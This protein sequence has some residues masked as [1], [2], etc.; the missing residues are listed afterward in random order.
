MTIKLKVFQLFALATV[1]LALPG[2]AQA[3]SFKH[4]GVNYEY[5]STVVNG[6]TVITGTADR[7][8]FRFVV[9]GRYVT[10]TYDY[11]P[12]DFVVPTNKRKRS[13]VAVR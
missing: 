2:A 10:G 8:P 12:V 9:R 4:K 5:T 13:A 6:R 11:R 3:E 7:T 1:A